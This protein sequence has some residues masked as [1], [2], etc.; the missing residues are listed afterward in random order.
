M[1][2][3]PEGE[4]AVLRADGA[5]EI[6]LQRLDRLRR[7]RVGVLDDAEVVE[8]DRRR[9]GD[10]GGDEP[11]LVRERLHRHLRDLLEARAAERVGDVRVVV[12]GDIR[13]GPDRVEQDREGI[14]EVAVLVPEDRV[15]RAHSDEPRG[16]VERRR[17][18]LTAERPRPRHRKVEDRRREARAAHRLREGGVVDVRSTEDALVGLG[19]GL[20]GDP[21]VRRASAVVDDAGEVEVDRLAVDDLHRRDR[22][23]RPRVDDTRCRERGPRSDQDLGL[24]EVRV[25]E[26]REDEGDPEEIGRLDRLRFEPRVV[27]VGVDVLQ[28]R[29]ELG[30]GIAD[31][32][33]LRILP[34]GEDLD[35]LRG[36]VERDLKVRHRVRDRETDPAELL[37]RLREP[38]AKR[39]TLR[40]V[41]DRAVH[42]PGELL[43][44]LRQRCHRLTVLFRSCARRRSGRRTVVP[45]GSWLSSR[46]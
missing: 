1:L 15:V 17:D 33:E 24:A 9:T 5:D 42:L 28:V 41:R 23:P 2:P 21:L 12:R 19:V 14:V 22:L 31:R 36:P 35:G 13:D 34:R 20:L 37:L 4:G 43:L 44:L 18:L 30:G 6:H 11:V 29:V 3:A 32:V 46:A 16:L 38:E 8:R 27:V 10:G 25:A 26:G 39:V 45:L 40:A 7:G